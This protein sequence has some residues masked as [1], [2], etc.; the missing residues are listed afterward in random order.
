MKKLFAA[1]VCLLL[2]F[3]SILAQKPPL[4]VDSLKIGEKNVTGFFDALD[5][6][7]NLTS[8]GVG[9]TSISRGKLKDSAVDSSKLDTDA[10]IT[11]K[12]KDDAISSDKIKK[13]AISNNHIQDHAVDSSKIANK[14]VNSDKIDDDAVTA[15]QI[16][17][18]AIQTAHLG[19]GIVVNTKL[20]DGAVFGDKIA[21]YGI[22]SL[23]MANASVYER[24]IVD[25]AV[26]TDK[27]KDG[28]LTEQDLSPELL[29]TL[30]LKSRLT[31]NP[32]DLTL[33]LYITD[34]DTF[35]RVKELG[36]LTSHLADGTVTSAKIADGTITEQDIGN[37]QVTEDKLDDWSVSTVKMRDRA[38]TTVKIDT[39]AVTNP[40]IAH[41]AVTTDKISDLQ[42]TTK[43][44]ADEA[45]TVDKLDEDA[46]TTPKI[47][48]RNVTE[49]K[50][51]DGAV[52]SR[53]IEDSSITRQDIDYIINNML[54]RAVIGNY[55]PDDITLELTVID[56]DTLW[57][58][59]DAGITA[60]KLGSG[61]VMNEKLANDAVSTEKILNY[62]IH[63]ADLH[64]EVLAGFLT[65]D[66]IYNLGS[67][68]LFIEPHDDIQAVIDTMTNRSASNWYTL[69]L[70][71]G[72]HTL[73]QTLDLYPYITLMGLGDPDD[74]EIYANMDSSLVEADSG[75]VT[76]K[77]MTFRNDAVLT[78]G[79]LSWGPKSPVRINIS[80]SLNTIP[81]PVTLENL[82][83]NYYCNNVGAD[84]SGIY[85]NGYF[86]SY[87]D[88]GTIIRDCFIQRLSAGV[89]NYGILISATG[90][91]SSINSLANSLII[92]DCRVYNCHYG[93]SISNVQQEFVY[94]KDC[95][96]N[97]CN[98][99]IGV[100]STSAENT[101]DN[102]CIVNILGGSIVNG[103]SY[104]IEANGSSNCYATVNVKGVRNNPANVYDGTY[105]VI[106]NLDNPEGG[107]T[108][109]SI[110]D[111]TIAM[112]DIS[113]PVQEEIRDSSRV[114]FQADTFK[115][116]SD[117]VKVYADAD[118]N[119]VLY[120]KLKGERTL[121]EL[122]EASSGAGLTGNVM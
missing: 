118:G 75:L 100:S 97:L 39:G 31:L 52:N 95:I 113:L 14:A 21:N 85:L 116:A 50:L 69:L 10:V 84:I 28:T 77:N 64:P 48:D 26:T 107:V 98:I 87:P 78:T 83:I 6:E 108:T 63:L 45:V 120:D 94:I 57:Q 12:I 66:S 60:G 104:D 112:N 17:A 92:E 8:V 68:I 40:I 51:A 25:E 81:R 9:D 3:T 36:I 54:D 34:P 70:S 105:A 43:K 47:K 90:G 106:N 80:S 101:G 37:R 71:P 33:E 1:V 121:T 46:V 53:G 65:A 91:S 30:S 110:L 7:N 58:V 67:N 111:N 44:I 16:A 103:P 86:D 109:V 13:D 18:L 117:T 62:T 89:G 41:E 73:T 76:I 99:S 42:V 102:D 59:K 88:W 56:N 20:A 2:I 72:R 49:A 119:L 96:T 29:A 61:A 114:T 79:G 122:T 4:N 115:V 19:P 82:N 74:T 55:L 27:V 32:D 24:A 5:E 15:N 11:D 23:K 93:I 22:T 38:V 35:F